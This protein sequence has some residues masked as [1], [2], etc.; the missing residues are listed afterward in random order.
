MLT[1]LYAIAI[2]LIRKDIRDYRILST[3]R[4]WQPLSRPR[5]QQ[6]AKFRSYSLSIENA[7]RISRERAVEPELSTLEWLNFIKRYFSNYL[8]VRASLI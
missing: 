6:L 7:P 2:S 1:R 5:W 8:R 4:R 3:G